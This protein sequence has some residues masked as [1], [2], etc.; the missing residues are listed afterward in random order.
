MLRRIIVLTTSQMTI[1]FSELHLE[2]LQLHTQTNTLVTKF[3]LTV[4]LRHEENE[5]AKNNEEDVV[6]HS[7]DGLCIKQSQGITLNQSN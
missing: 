6:S 7:G 3:L 5:D 4:S 1:T 2:I